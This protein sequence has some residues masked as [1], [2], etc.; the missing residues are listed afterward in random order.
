MTELPPHPETAD[1][2]R[3]VYGSM[4]IK[5]FID[6]DGV[7]TVART[8]SAATFMIDTRTQQ[9]VQ[10]GGEGQLDVASV[11]FISHMLAKDPAEFWP[12]LREQDGTT[13]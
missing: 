11:D 5:T 1:E 6:I 3:Y 12:D 13:P 10:I 7:G 9:L 8:D 4:T 2:N